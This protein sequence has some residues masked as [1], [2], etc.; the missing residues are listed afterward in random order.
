MLTLK[1]IQYELTW[2]HAQNKDTSADICSCWKCGPVIYTTNSTD[3]VSFYGIMSL[4][5]VWVLCR[6][7]G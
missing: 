5:K 2:T 1:S 3:L 7:A 4:C 6:N